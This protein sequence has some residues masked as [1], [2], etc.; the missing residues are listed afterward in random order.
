MFI[1]VNRIIPFILL[2]FISTFAFA[3]KNNSNLGKVQIIL[4]GTILDKKTQ[5]PING[6]NIY[7]PD[8]KKGTVT[9]ALGQYQIL[10]LLTGTYLI[11]VS[12]VGYKTVIQNIHLTENLTQNFTLELSVVEDNTVVITGSNKASLI[13]RNPIAI[14][15]IGKQFLQQNLTTNI[16]DAIAKVPGINAV[17]TGPNIAKPFIRGMGYNRILTLY[18]GVRNEGQQW[19]DEHGIEV[20]E[21]SVE[22]V[23]V[24]KGP[25]SLIYGADAL[26]GVVNLIPANFTNNGKTVGQ[27]A[28]ELQTNNKLL[29]CTGM[30][31]GNTNS[32]IW[33]ARAS[34]KQ[35][36]N[37]INANDG[38]VYN[39]GF[40]EANINGMIG[41][42][43]NWGYSHLGFS[44]FNDLQEIPDGS[45]D[46]ATRKFT[47]QISEIDSIRQIVDHSELNTYKI[48]NIHQLVQNAKIYW[49]N[50]YNFKN[51]TNWNLNIGYQNSTRREFNHPM[52]AIPGL[53]LQLNTITYDIK[54]HLNQIKDWNIT[55]GI[56][57]MYQTNK[58]EK[59]TEFIIPS[60]T[61]FDIGA[62][63]FAKKSYN[64]LDIAF[65][66]RNDIRK[67]NNNATFTKTNIVTGFEKIVFDN[68]TI[69]S[70]KIFSNYKKTFSGLT[71][72]IGFAYSF[73]KKLSVKFNLAR[74]FRTPNIAEISSNG[75]HPG[76]NIYQLGNSKF[77]SEFSLQQ[78]VGLTYDAEHIS[79]KLE[80][81]NNNIQNYIY[82][83]KLLNKAGNDSIIVAGNQTFQYQQA[84]ANLHGAEFT[85][86][87]HPHPFDW[88]HI[89]NT[90][91][92]VFGK[93][94]QRNY[95]T[96]LPQIPP[97]RIITELQAN[98]KKKFI[99]LQYFF[100][101]VQMENNATQNRILL[102]NET[103]TPTANYTLV[104]LGFGGG[105]V[106]KKRK[107]IF[108]ISLLAN[109]I[110]NI[111]YQSHLNR[112][113]Y[114]EPYPNNTT[115]KFGIYNMGR[116]IALKL[117][118]P[119]QFNKN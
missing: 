78:D 112:L 76:T 117:S 53:Y 100:G 93:K 98:A 105:F 81:F 22:K 1:I 47:K 106:N 20:D 99:G 51:G 32:L 58:I 77:K 119:L 73:S 67:F 6:A 90:F 52:V 65:G 7:L 101:K 70:A 62:F 41:V 115:G 21:N 80:L 111:S 60:Y 56:N 30:L 102:E 108:N 43:K 15:A 66:C 74:G 95:F 3:N 55:T 104:N 17:T 50:N 88:L 64:K 36:T 39:T 92:I 84:K 16:I 94:K 27:I 110:F 29:E 40:K 9:N 11:E 113:K 44:F 72:S 85:I 49:A 33:R 10:G 68:D 19:G 28:T 118:F 87:I 54:Y 35:A 25:A 18:D 42:N 103:E 69:G 63:I 46:S 5:L 89:E 75:V 2:I 48:S 91:A 34:Y 13:K 4:N 96:Y 59:G 45:R 114:F 97:V 23:E 8:L 71:G 14:K 57:G 61:Q 38:R 31:S 107:T 37:Y 109:N 12:F 79:V 26:A 116:N 82:N 83:N 24:I 86:D